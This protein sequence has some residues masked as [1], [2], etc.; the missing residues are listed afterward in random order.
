MTHVAAIMLIA[1][2]AGLGGEALEAGLVFERTRLGDVTYEGAA[3]FDVNRDGHPDIVSG[4][5]WFEGPSF[6]IEHRI[7]EPK[8]VED[9]YDDF[10]SYPMDVDGDGWLDIITGGWWNE[11]VYWLENPG[12]T[13]E[14]WTRHLIA[15]IGN[16]ERAC[17][18]DING[19]GHMD[20]VPNTPG[21]PQVVIELQRDEAG[22]GMAAFTVNQ[23]TDVA[24]GHG[25]G[26]G[27]I[28]G[29]GRGE[30]LFKHGWVEMPEKP[31]EQ[32]WTIHR[33]FKLFESSSVPILVHD[34]NG[35]GSNDI[36]V[37][38]AHEYGLAWW[39]QGQDDG[40]QT[41]W[42]RHDIEP[43]RSQFHDIQLADI[44]GDGVEELVTG[45]RWRA[46]MGND[47]GADD[48]LGVY[49]FEVEGAKLDRH[50]IDYGPA[51]EASGVGIYFWVADVDG[52]G[53]MDIVAPGKEGLFLFK[54]MGGAK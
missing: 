52:N 43:G 48:P 7:Y 38:G 2:G 28:T 30:I 4:G 22:K 8:R 5:V 17:F 49:W 26:F 44:D 10:S 51:G 15:K 1:W 24:L 39:E 21:A 3:V 18:Y 53:H 46:H 13:G 47:P 19:D 16:V 6:G 25:L 42:T 45:K 9:Y 29:D 31:F 33:D 27:D 34:V 14:A 12:G 41:V 32:P 50:T 54:N 40:G 23:A 36:I 20:I 35:D 11:S 37:G